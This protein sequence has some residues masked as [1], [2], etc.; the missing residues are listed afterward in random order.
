M[1]HKD[2]IVIDRGFLEIWIVMRVRLC[3]R[4]ASGSA[5]HLRITDGKVGRARASEANASTIRIPISISIDSHPP[6]FPPSRGA[7]RR[8]R[9]MII[10]R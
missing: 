5:V 6:I 2:F 3:T 1:G 10:L 8:G 9:E 7:Q 4:P